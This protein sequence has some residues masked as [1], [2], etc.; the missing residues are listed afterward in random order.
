[1]SQSHSIVMQKSCFI[2]NK[3][4]FW[5]QGYIEVIKLYLGN[6]TTLR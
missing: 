3:Y 4:L 1:M 2:G 6:K 5:L